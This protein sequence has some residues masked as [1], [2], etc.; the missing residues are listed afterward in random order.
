MDGSTNANGQV[1]A[2]FREFKFEALSLDR[3]S[4]V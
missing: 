2:G 1:P 4:V 3:K